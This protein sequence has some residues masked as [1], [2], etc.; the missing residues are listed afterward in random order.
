ML[1]IDATSAAAACRQDG[2]QPK[3]TPP[4]RR[5]TQYVRNTTHAPQKK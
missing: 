3:N 5:K 2:S 1:S 4:P